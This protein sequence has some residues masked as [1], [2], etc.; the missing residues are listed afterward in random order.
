MFSNNEED[1]V[2]ALWTSLVFQFLLSFC[3]LEYSGPALQ[4]V[5]SD[6]GVSDQVLGRPGRDR[7]QDLD[8]GAGKTQSVRHHEEDRCWY[9]TH[10]ERSQHCQKQVAQFK[11][12]AQN[13]YTMVTQWTLQMIIST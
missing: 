7:Q 13:K 2:G 4:P 10:E 3:L 6:F 8:S 11:Y 1:A 12:I 5:P 9:S